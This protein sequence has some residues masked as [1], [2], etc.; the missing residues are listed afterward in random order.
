MAR[1][2]SPNYP[3]FSLPEALNRVKVI[4]AAEQHLAAPKDV[5]VRHLGYGG[6]NGASTKVLSAITKYGLLE[7]AANEKMRVSPLA[8]S[9][10]FPANPQEKAE[11]IREVALKPPLFAEIY[12]EWD[13]AMPSDE[14]LR[15]YLIRK[16]FATD[17]LDKVI[18]SY[19]ETIDLVTRECSVYP[20][21][22]E[23]IAPQ[24]Q[25]KRPVQTQTYQQPPVDTP[26]AVSIIGD[27]I[28]V[29][30]TL[31]DAASVEKLIA[32]LN[33]TKVLLPN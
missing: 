30:A 1:V 6:L 17:A 32:A 25:E 20:V 3:A 13:G 22:S 23:P 26:M 31:A 14:N 5:L 27:K 4:H 33:A 15:S 16:N 24:N 7:E 12:A 8:T 2:R 9:I 29:S 28:Q 19:K 11:A 10:M 21:E 18:Q